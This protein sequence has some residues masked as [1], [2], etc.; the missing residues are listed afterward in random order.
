MMLEKVRSFLREVRVELEKVTWPGR[1]EVQAATLVI[2]AL[3]V[4][5]AVFIGGVDFVVSRVLGL[6][7]RL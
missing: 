2:I 3:V 4:L 6:F 7:F 5:L 1:K